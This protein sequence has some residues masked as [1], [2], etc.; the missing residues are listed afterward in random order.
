MC[1]TTAR[2]SGTGSYAISE[3]RPSSSRS[4]G[5]MLLH[6]RTSLG[7]SSAR[8]GRNSARRRPDLDFWQC[9][10]TPK[11][12]YGGELVCGWIGRLFPYTATGER[13]PF[14]PWSPEDMHPRQPRRRR[15]AGLSGGFAIEEEQVPVVTPM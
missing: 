1:A 3:R 14:V 10:Y 9:I 15:K 8:W 6:G 12:V 5:G 7:A 13:I 2:L 4:T 11:E